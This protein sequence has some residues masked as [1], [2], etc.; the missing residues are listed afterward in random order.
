M[1]A[2]QRLMARDQ[3]TRPLWKETHVWLKLERSR[4]PG[5]GSIAGAIDYN[6]YSWPALTRQREDGSVPIENNFIKRQIKPWAMG[7]RAWLFC[8]SEF[9]GQRAAIVMGPVQS[10]K[11]NGHGPWPTCTTGSSGFPAPQQP[12]RRA[13]AATLEGARRLTS[14]RRKPSPTTT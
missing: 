2:Q 11:H 5:S 10:A 7:R 8:G 4:V 6:L 14:G 3:L 13:A 1:H 9:A 12:H